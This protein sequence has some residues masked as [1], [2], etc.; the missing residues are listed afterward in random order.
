MIARIW[1]TTSQLE[2]E[3]IRSFLRAF[4]IGAVV[5]S[6]HAF[7]VTGFPTPVTSF[8]VAVSGEEAKTALGLIF[9]YW[10]RMTG[11]RLPVEDS[12]ETLEDCRD[13]FGI[14]ETEEARFQETVVRAKRKSRLMWWIVIVVHLFWT[15]PFL[16]F[17]TLAVLKATRAAGY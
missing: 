10:R 9:Q 12:G 13:I 7:Y 1:S 8:V 6:S 15:F 17:L 11:N 5:E 14:D 2:A 4:D 16:P 3:C